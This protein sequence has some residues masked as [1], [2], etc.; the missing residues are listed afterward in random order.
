[1]VHPI[2][3]N[4]VIVLLA[5]SFIGEVSIDDMDVIG[6]FFAALGAMM[7]FNSSYISRFQ[8]E[9]TQEENTS[10]EDNKQDDE[11]KKDEIEIL[12][13]SIEKIREELKKQD[14]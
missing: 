14:I 6:N 13:E 11:D 4:E 12:K 8:V 7:I 5:N 1:M 10:K 2:L 9:S 3:I